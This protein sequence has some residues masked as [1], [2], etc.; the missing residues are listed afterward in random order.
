[1]Q[2]C[3]AKEGFF[4]NF[5]GIRSSITHGLSLSTT[6]PLTPYFSSSTRFGIRSLST[7]LWHIYT[8]LSSLG[9]PATWWTSTLIGG[10]HNND[11]FCWKG[12]VWFLSGTQSYIKH[13]HCPWVVEQYILIG[14][15]NVLLWI[16]E[17]N[18]FVKLNLLR[19]LLP[20]CKYV[21]S[22]MNI[23][24]LKQRIRCIFPWYIAL[25]AWFFVIEPHLKTLIV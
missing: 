12:I 17:C 19:F 20:I 23:G 13:P 22:Q 7:V 16:C 24:L 14:R 25:C 2:W 8:D 15:N 11:G 6:F 4:Q 1:M 21:T 5:K 3:T 10:M 18:A 9:P